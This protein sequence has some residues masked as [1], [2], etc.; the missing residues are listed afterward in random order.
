MRYGVARGDDWID[1]VVHEAE[2]VTGDVVAIELGKAGGGELPRW[3][4]GSHVAVRCGPE[5]V[6]HYS[7]CGPA[8][9]EDR[10]RLGIK[11]EPEGRGGS[12]W[13]AEHARPGATLAISL[14]RDHF[15]LRL[16]RAGYCFIS[17]GIGMTPILAML[18]RLQREGVRARW[19]HLCRSPADLA[20][21]D[22]VAELAAFHDV[23]VH[24]DSSAGGLFDLQGELERTAPE[25]E[26]YC[27]G[28]TPVMEAVRDFAR[29][30]GREDRYH[31]EFFAAPDAE[32]ADAE[33][34]GFVVVQHSTGREVR[35]GEGDT[36]LAA[37]R[38]AGID[39][40]SECEYGVCGHCATGVVSGTPEHYDSYLTEA[41]RASNRIVMPCVSRCQ[42]D[43][44]E[45]DI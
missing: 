40:P 44:I 21:A 36:M 45:L 38:K 6:R 24:H 8:E 25:V 15:P 10:Y 9:R 41:E 30:R 16:G 42:G 23:H 39:M 5:I 17:G 11:L 1:V 31:F 28:P 20:F 18:R 34:R 4:P 19:V 32:A 13:L 12:R 29:S 35:V 2:R 7:L 3:T 33:G 43:R 22:S 14:P 27:C 26:V 37:L